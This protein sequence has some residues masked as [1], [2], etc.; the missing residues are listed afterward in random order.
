MIRIGLVDLDTSHPLAF[1]KILRTLPG[2]EV[3]ALWDGHD[4]WPEGYDR[5]FAA[6]QNIPV[7]CARL[8]EMP[9][10]VD[11]AMIH[12][13]N[14]D[15][16]IDR[17]LVFFKAGKPVLIDKP[18]VGSVRDC[19]RLLNLK[20]KYGAA[21]FGGSSLR[22]AAEVTALRGSLAAR[23]DLLSVAASG[24]GD[25]F[26]YGIHT[27][28]MLQGIAG[29]GI[30]T[31]KPLSGARGPVLAVEYADGLVGILHLEMPFNE[32]SLTAYTSGGVRTRTVD[33]GGLYEPFLRTFVAMLGGAQ[34]ESGIEGPV[35]A[36]R[37]HIA[38]RLALEKGTLQG[39]EGLP[40][41]AGFDGRAFAA[42]YAASKRNQA[43]GAGHA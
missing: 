30:R 21:V 29:T 16:H 9:A 18:V 35:E 34:I 38:A 10:H 42:E 2:V 27:T 3:T 28:E 4:V 5:R 31:V 6:E 17:A 37:V 26:S 41:G 13:T 19:D 15:A 23:G 14:W 11:A 43:S 32:W 12:G 20:E 1:T 8:E 22:Y 39:L 33:M 25:F 40:S 24:P 7:V 36:V